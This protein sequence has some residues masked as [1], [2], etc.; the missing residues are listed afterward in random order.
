MRTK[1]ILLSVVGLSPQVLTETLFALHQQAKKVDEI[2]VITTRMGKD[3][4]NASLLSP[5][6]GQYHRYLIDYGISPE[7]IAFGFDHVHV[8]ADEH[9]REIDDIEDEYD[10]ELLLKRSLELTF[11]LTRDPD[12]AVFFS[13]AGGR[14]TMSAC[15]MVAAQMYARSQDRVYHV[16]VSPEFENSRDFYFP[17]KISVPIELRDNLGNPYTKE[18]RYARITLIP[19]PFVSIRNQLSSELLKQPKDPATLMLSIIREEQFQMIID[20]AEAK[21]VYKNH[22]LDMMPARLALYAF[23]ALQKKACNKDMT[24]CHGCKE[25]YLD[26]NGIYERQQEIA[27][28]YRQIS[29]GRENDVLSDSG[30]TSL[31]E[32]NFNAYKSKIRKDLEQGFG[33]YG[34]ADLAI[35]SVGKRPDTRYGIKIDRNRIRVIF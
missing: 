21:L 34:L 7:G 11:S 33:L 17:P 20:L 9:G 18:T 14:K 28:I 8:V 31:D 6:D 29:G 35:E 27:E 13:I 30:I 15:L 16:L 24:S 5:H 19:V 3:A 2:H 10:N 23:F 26:I 1:N 12:S 22:E 25:C 32:R 4:I